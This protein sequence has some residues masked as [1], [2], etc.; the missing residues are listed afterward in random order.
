MNN[1][2][3]N[4]MMNLTVSLFG[5]F[6]DN[7]PTFRCLTDVV[8]LAKSEQMERL[9]LN[10]RQL[11]AYAANAATPVAQAIEAKN[12]AD[13]LKQQ[14][15]SFLSNVYCEHGK[16]RKHIVRFLPMAGFDVDH[17]S[18]QEVL[19]LMERLKADPH[20][21]MAQPSCSRRGVHFVIRHDADQWLNSLWNGS[22]LQPYYCVWQQARAYVQTTFNVTVDDKCKNPEHI[23]G[24]C[25][26]EVIH[27]APEATAL[28]IDTALNTHDMQH[29]ATPPAA[30]TTTGLAAA[31]TYSA[32]IYDVA[33]RIIRRIEDKGTR[34]AP[35]SRN[36]FVLRFALAAN[37]YGVPQSEAEGFCQ[38]HFAEADFT[39]KEICTTI[40]SAYSKTMEHGTIC[41]V[42]A[43]A[44]QYVKN[45]KVYNSLIINDSN[46]HKHD[47]ATAQ[48]AQTAQNSKICH[49]EI[50]FKQTFSDKIDEQDWCDFF[51]PVLNS[52]DDAEG[53]DKMIL[54]TLV[55]LSGMLPNIYGIYSGHTV[56]PPLYLLFYG[57]TASRKGE[58]GSCQFITKPLKQEIV[59]RYE[60]E[61]R[62][63]QMAHSLWESKGAKASEKATR[64]EEPQEPEY[65]SPIIPAN[66]SAS[67]AYIALKANGG[68]GIMFETEA[69]TL[70]QSL[71]SDYGDYSSGLLAAF[72]HE[73]IKMNR[74]RDK[75]RF[76]IDEPRLAIGLTCTAGQLPKLFPTFEDGLGNRFL[77]Y[78]LNRKLTWINPFKQIDKPLDEVYEELGKQALVLYHEMMNL[79]ERRIQ[80]ML[81]QEQVSQFNTFFS[82]L[83]MEQ[84]AMLGDGISSFIFRLGLSAFRIAMIL[85]LLRRYSEWDKSAPLFDGNTQA[86]LCGD[87]DFT[88]AL[89]IMNTLV[90]HTATIYAALAKED[91]GLLNQQLAELTHAER[92]I[93]NALNDEFTTN[94]LKNVAIEKNI[95]ADTARRYLGKFANTYHIVERV[96]NGLYRKTKKQA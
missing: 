23:F 83:L 41:A 5:N 43:D 54:G 85:T 87:K 72:H 67:A 26:D 6:Y 77:Y 89:T 63:Y 46:F 64:G 12:R 7:E 91:E 84:F 45:N 10:I 69:A 22:D 71:L 4:G 70:T 14:L 20:V 31:G 11:R 42:C 40:Q 50:S 34:F 51:L 32:N 18:E 16:M 30:P 15:P 25:H 73:P 52:M 29:D 37:K 28:H 95:N 38:D 75:V 88:M 57:P 74:V 24:I 60:Q 58:I 35:G 93:Y 13:K 92:I 79:R 21:V 39:E 47:C 68:W 1:V 81:T 62:E 33:E 8:A 65:R 96:K 82:D 80:F 55:N 17:I 59:G 78:G 48:T 19:T 36:D 90:N 44:H 49:E 3:N 94:D 66:S 61:L 56:Y 86:L 2:M 27:F 53:K 76:D 9:T